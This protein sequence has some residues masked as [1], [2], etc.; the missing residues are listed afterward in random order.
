MRENYVATTAVDPITIS[1][2]DYNGS[3]C[4]YNVIVF[5]PDGSKSDS[6]QV[7]DGIRGLSKCGIKVKDHILSVYNDPFDIPAFYVQNGY[8]DNL[9]YWW[10]IDNLGYTLDIREAKR[11]TKLEADKILEGNHQKKYKVWECSYIDR[12]WEAL[13]HAIDTQYLDF[14]NSKDE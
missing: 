5:L 12:I 13:V 14:N 8:A 7:K 6:I 11:F 9:A 2:G 10:R 3:W 1:E 4:G